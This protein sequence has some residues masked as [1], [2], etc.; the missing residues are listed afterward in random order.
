MNNYKPPLRVEKQYAKAI[1][2]VVEEILNLRQDGED[3]IDYL[4]RSAQNPLLEDAAK[5]IA[6]KFLF[7]LLRNNKSKWLEASRGTKR[8]RQ[9]Y[10][11]L[12]REMHGP[13]GMMVD[14]LIDRNAFFITTAPLDISRVLTR[15]IMREQQKGRRAN[16]IANDI[17]EMLPG[18]AKNRVNLIARTETSKASTA[19][20]RAQSYELGLEW[21]IWRTSKDS[22]VRSSH[23]HM[24]DVLI[25]WADPPSPELLVRQP[26]MGRYNAGE[27][28]NCR[29]YAEPVIDLDDI[30]WPHKVYTNGRIVTMSRATFQNQ[31]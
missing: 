12:Q 28:F 25:K 4:I 9:I 29:C 2:K 17:Q 13:V 14:A 11:A 3:I 16:E 15:K 5:I 18:V 31:I 24:E 27:I 7:N 21:Y 8:A 30:K 26:N 23:A 6:K 20:T 19:L 1:L 22:R 10:I